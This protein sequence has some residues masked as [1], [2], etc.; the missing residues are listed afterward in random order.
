MFWRS[1]RK[2]IEQYADKLD[3][4]ENTVAALQ[5]IAQDREGLLKALRAA[6][7]ENTRLRRENAYLRRALDGEENRRD[8]LAEKVDC[9]TAERDGLQREVEYLNRVV[10]AAETGFGT[11][12]FIKTMLAAGV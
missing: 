6:E 9:L 11:A 2:I 4:A 3:A 12:E 8:R 7:K 5:V 1:K 10:D